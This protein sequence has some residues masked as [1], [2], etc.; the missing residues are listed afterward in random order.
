MAVTVVNPNAGTSNTGLWNRLVLALL[1]TSQSDPKGQ[2]DC[3]RIDST[4]VAVS[5]RVPVAAQFPGKVYRVLWA[6]GSVNAASV[7]PSSGS[8]D[9]IQNLSSYVFAGAAGDTGI[10]V[11]SDGGTNWIVVSAPYALPAATSIAL[12][13]VLIVGSGTGVVTVPRVEDSGFIPDAV[14]DPAY[15][16]PAA[17]AITKGEVT[18]QGTPADATGPNVPLIEAAFGV[19]GT[20][21]SPVVI[22][23]ADIATKNFTVIN[24]L[25]VRFA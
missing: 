4:G 3:V 23:A 8:A 7:L 1:T 24:G 14:I 5:F 9:T 13:G 22:T 16:N 15:V 17:T 11:V 18:V 2:W 10:D 6:A 20:T 19:I 25:I 21:A 12:G